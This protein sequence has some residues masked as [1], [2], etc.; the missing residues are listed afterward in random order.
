M[1]K[2]WDGTKAYRLLTTKDLS[3]QTN[4]IKLNYSAQV[5]G[6]TGFQ[7]PSN[8]FMFIGAGSNDSDYYLHITD[9]DGTTEVLNLYIGYNNDGPATMSVPVITGQKAYI[10]PSCRIVFVPYY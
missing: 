1:P 4:P 9:I 3:Q 2:Y 7:A 5:S 10:S 6:K 8:G